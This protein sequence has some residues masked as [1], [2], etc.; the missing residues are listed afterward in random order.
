MNKY[1]FLLV[2]FILFNACQLESPVVYFFKDGNNPGFY[3][4]GLAF[5]TAPSVL[6]QAG[7]SGDK[8][9]T[10][11]VVVFEGNNSL[12]IHWTS[13]SGGDWTTYIIAPGFPFQNIAVTDSLSMMVF[14]PDGLSKSAMPKI[15]M[16]VAPNTS[17]SK[18]YN[19]GD[20]NNDIPANV[21]TE[22]RFPLHVFFNDPGN[23]ALDFKRTKAII[24]TQNTADNIDHLIYVD[25]VKTYKPDTVA[26]ALT[27]PANLTA[28]GY[29]SHV[30]LRWTEG[31]NAKKY[32]VWSAAGND[33]FTLRKIIQPAN[34][35]LDFVTDL[36]NNLKLKYK[37]RAVDDKNNLSS[38]TNEVSTSTAS[39]S[40]SALLTMVQRYTFRFFWE[41]AHPI[42][43]MARERNATPDVVT[44]GGTGFGI[45]SIVV[46]VDRGFITRAE[47]VAHI[48]KIISF[49]TKADRF[50]GIFPHWLNGTTGKVIPFSPKD[51]G[52]DLVESSFLFQ[53]LLTA[54]QF[55]NGSSADEVQ[56]RSGVKS[57]WEAAEWDWYLKG[58]GNV[59][60]WHWSPNFDWQMNFPLKG[61]YEALITYILGVASPTH[62]IPSSVYHQ[63]WAGLPGY[64][65]GKTFYGNKLFVGPNAGG[66]LFFAHYSFIGFDPRNIKDAYANYFTHN[67]NQSLINWAYC[68]ENPKQ[69]TGYSGDNWGLTASDDTDGY[70][71]HEPMSNTDNGTISPT[72]A[73]SSMPYT[74]VQSLAALKYFYRTQGAKLF[75]LMGF[76]DAYNL[77][78]NWVADSYLAI[79]QGPIVTMIE[80]YRTGLL[81]KYFMQSPEIKPALDAI[82]FT[83]DVMVTGI[84]DAAIQTEI[85]IF[86]NPATNKCFLEINLPS[87]KMLNL[88]VYDIQGRHIKKLFENRNYKRGKQMIEVA[89]DG[90]APGQYIIKL[91]GNNLEGVAKITVI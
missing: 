52:G 49:L 43:G 18:K 58:G 84:K 21:W 73:L 14:A 83:N 41:Y 80:N 74:P 26:V 20:Y 42:S 10:S 13:K 4:S 89:L 47:G 23:S 15:F 17:K 50:H 56:L 86:P 59:L 2:G 22:I 11:N 90:L 24:L 8:I 38:F 19:L 33:S 66:P 7:T 12:K 48:N 31:K 27:P 69:W 88:N 1:C 9:P 32:E 63:G 45:S 3:D 39:M 53:G 72:A 36:G 87:T 37:I 75:G 51:D 29:D 16:E 61:Y 35:A 34:A 54:R 70:L 40:D 57:L 71:A 62:K 81:W 91:I 44:I 46:A 6:E 77:T 76:Y 85:K 55:F 79:D 82:G 60:Y 30:E 25:N 78:R 28:Q 5:K 68:K 65:N 64:V 67:V